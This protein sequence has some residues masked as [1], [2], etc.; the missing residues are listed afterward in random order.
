MYIFLQV[1][2]SANAESNLNSIPLC[3]FFFTDFRNAFLSNRR[4]RTLIELCQ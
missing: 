3:V 4:G 1:N 2:L